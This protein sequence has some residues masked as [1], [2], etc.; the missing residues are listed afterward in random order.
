MTKKFDFAIIGGG[1]QGLILAYYLSKKH[2][3]ALI[4]KEKELGG[5]ISC[6]KVGNTYLEKYYHHLFVG[7]NL[8]FSLFNELNIR[9]KLIWKN[10]KSGFYF[11]KKIHK[12]VSP[13]D[14]FTF[15]LLKFKDKISFVL[16]LLKIKS[17]K[18]PSSLEN[19]LA[20]DWLTKNSNKEVYEKMFKPLLLNKFGSD[21]HTSASWIISRIKLRSHARIKGEKIYY[22][23]GSFK[24]LTD[25]LEEKAKKNSVLIMKSNPFTR[26]QI[27]DNNIK[28]IITK[29]GK[30][31][32]T[33]YISTISPQITFNNVELPKEYKKKL[34]FLEYLGCICAIFTIEEPLS[35]L[36]WVNVLEDT[37]FKAII[38]HTNFQDKNKY[39]ANIIYLTSYHSI[40]SNIWNK[41]NKTILNTFKND[42]KKLF[43]MVKIKS[44]TIFKEKYSDIL[45]KRNLSKNMLSF[46]TPFKNLFIIG[47]FN[48]Y[49]ERGINLQ[50]N[51]TKKFLNK[52]LIKNVS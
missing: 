1:F 17:I 49:P 12:F 5:A 50:L 28:S 44:Q 25:K 40:D 27:K 14:L 34:D 51:L 19:V 42:L 4:E 23:E 18:N 43:P 41:N 9:D 37:I 30:I 38:E 46:E 35:K 39:G 31:Y 33:N 8:L 22:L 26:F 45:N 29:K 48:T 36:Y 6:I 24:I 11:D 21:N 3:V 47:M 2:S 13:F 10:V 7:D 52:E 15:K 32:A 20:R 16:L